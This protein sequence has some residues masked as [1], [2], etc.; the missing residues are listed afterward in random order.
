MQALEEEVSSLTNAIESFPENSQMW[1]LLNSYLDRAREELEDFR[2]KQNNVAGGGEDV[3]DRSRNDVIGGNK[4]ADSNNTSNEIIYRKE[5]QFVCGMEF[6]DDANNGDPL[7]KTLYTGQIDLESQLPHGLGTMRKDDAAGTMLEGEWE[8]GTLVKEIRTSDC[9]VS[10]VGV[11]VRADVRVALAPPPPMSAFPQNEQNGEIITQ[12]SGNLVLPPPL[13]T[14]AASQIEEI[15]TSSSGNLANAAAVSQRIVEI[16]EGGE[17]SIGGMTKGA[18]QSVPSLPVPDVS[19]DPPP[20]AA[21]ASTTRFKIIAPSGH[22]GLVV[23]KTGEGP[24]FVRSLDLSSPMKDQIR[25][26]DKIIAINGV[27]LGSMTPAEIGFLLSSKRTKEI[28]IVRES[29]GSISKVNDDDASEK[30]LLPKATLPT[31]YRKSVDS[32]TTGTTLSSTT[33]PFYTSHTVAAGDPLPKVTLGQSHKEEEESI[34]S[35]MS[36]TTMSHTTAQT[37]ISHPD[38][39]KIYK[40]MVCCFQGFDEE[41]DLLPFFVGDEA[42]AGSSALDRKWLSTSLLS[43]TDV[44]ESGAND[45]TITP[46]IEESAVGQF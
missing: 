9:G 24:T 8:Y 37:F 17:G 10:V 3:R 4:V 21:A 38:I 5:E 34:G 22:L 44:P 40:D 16:Q 45:S 39:D 25:V 7:G 31:S 36:G 29:E 19:L 18:Y 12:S 26:N 15:I 28:S 46:V 11:K 6:F 27:E 35:D 33:D 43:S 14:G 41:S 13:P 42:M 30:E 32:D 1:L 20:P 23:D 2:S